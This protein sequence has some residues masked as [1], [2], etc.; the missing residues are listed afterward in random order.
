MDIH[1]VVTRSFAGL[2]RG[3]IVADAARIADILKGEHAHDVVRVIS[4]PPT[5]SPA[6]EG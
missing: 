3:D 4:A 6:K 1:L 2:L 5:A